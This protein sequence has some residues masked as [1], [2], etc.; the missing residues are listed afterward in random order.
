MESASGLSFNHAHEHLK[1]RPVKSP[2]AAPPLTIAHFSAPC[3]ARICESVGT[4]VLE[5]D[6]SRSPPDSFGP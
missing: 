6:S 4:A 3:S 2:Y 5:I 1:S